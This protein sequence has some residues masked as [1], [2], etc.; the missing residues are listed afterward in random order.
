MTKAERKRRLGIL[1]K[2]QAYRFY[3]NHCT[4]I[5]CDDFDDQ[6]EIKTLYRM[7]VEF[8][9]TARREKDEVKST[10][11]NVHHIIASDGGLHPIDSNIKWDL[12]HGDYIQHLDIRLVNRISSDGNLSGDVILEVRVNSVSGQISVVPV[13]ANCFRIV[14]KRGRE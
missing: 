3:C 1:S 4:M 14:W 10:R 8:K 5:S 12:S 7:V 13:S 6:F 9:R 2:S 11:S